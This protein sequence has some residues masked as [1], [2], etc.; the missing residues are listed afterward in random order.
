MTRAPGRALARGALLA[1]T[2]SALAFAPAA[3]ALPTVTVVGRAVAIP[4]FA[5]TG[6]F[7]GAGAAVQARIRITGSEYAGSPPPL[8]GITVF[9]PAGV[10]LNA[11]AFPTCPERTIVEE[12][13]P[14]RCPKGSAAGPPGRV[15]GVV[16]FGETRVPE[17]ATVQSFFAPH[18]GFEFFTFGHSPVILEVPSTARVLPPS[19]G[20]GPE[21]TGAV[22]LVETVP[23]GAD[24]SVEEIDITI[25]AAL[26]TKHG[27]VYY[28]R[29]P[30]HCPHGGFKAKTIFTFATNGNPATPES[31]TVPVTAP[32]PRR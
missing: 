6:N 27:P 18:G 17:E 22:P 5:H 10:R 4:G 3:A 9:L 20:F 15:L 31:V 2:G 11:K 12:R 32:C 16:S 1:V 29:V 30:K 13:E 19:G 23:G 28:G 25:G 14:R 21:F 24:A 8:I 7:F 26:H